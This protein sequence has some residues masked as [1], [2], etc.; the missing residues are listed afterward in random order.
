[1]S[2]VDRILTC[3]ECGVGFPWTIQEQRDCAPLPAT[4][5]ACRTVLGRIGRWQQEA[6]P[7]VDRTQV[8]SWLRTDG[9][10][11]AAVSRLHAERHRGRFHVLL[12]EIGGPRAVG[13][14]LDPWEALVV[15]LWR[16]T[17]IQ[18]P[19]RPEAGGCLPAPPALAVLLEAVPVA[20]SGRPPYQHIVSV[21]TARACRRV[22]RIA[23]LGWILQAHTPLLIDPRLFPA[24]ADPPPWR[25]GP[26]SPLD[27]FVAQMEAL[28]D[29]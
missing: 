26:G 11:P 5:S 16:E 9:F 19:P 4:C 7:V 12:R 22:S 15:A 8:L 1:M 14:A 6:G 27:R 3:C 24:R 2:L 17:D 29:L 18:A 13:V 23:G 25:P 21:I 10:V 20:P 28:D